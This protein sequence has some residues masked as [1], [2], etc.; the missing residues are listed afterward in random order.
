MC[1]KLVLLQMSGQDDDV[2]NYDN[3]ASEDE[4]ASKKEDEDHL[5]AR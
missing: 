2:Y 1:N 3:E 5:N 4:R